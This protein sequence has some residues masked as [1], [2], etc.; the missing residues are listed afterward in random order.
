MHSVRVKK[1]LEYWLQCIKIVIAPPALTTPLATPRLILRFVSEQQVW[2]IYPGAS[3]HCY[4]L[5]SMSL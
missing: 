5:R 2:M 1:K 3:I 4:W